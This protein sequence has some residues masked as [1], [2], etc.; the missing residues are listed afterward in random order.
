MF[1]CLVG[2]DIVVDRDRNRGLGCRKQIKKRIMELAK[3]CWIQQRIL[4]GF[5]VSSVTVRSGKRAWRH[6][7]RLAMAF[8]AC[9][10]PEP[11]AA[12]RFGCRGRRA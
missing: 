11:S 12:A 10:A 8:L 2:A 1:S 3:F 5:F 4:S 9:A 6:A 7:L